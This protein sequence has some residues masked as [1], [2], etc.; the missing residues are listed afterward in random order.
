MKAERDEL[1]QKPDWLMEQMRLS[2][3]KLYGASSERLEVELV[4]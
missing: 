3:K 4:G 2:R 1:N